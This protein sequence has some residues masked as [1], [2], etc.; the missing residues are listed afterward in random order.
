MAE[1]KEVEVEVEVG[2]TAKRKA[3]DVLAKAR[4]ALANKARLKRKLDELKEQ[5]KEQKQLPGTVLLQET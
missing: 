1:E 2:A 4:E 5:Q 3:S